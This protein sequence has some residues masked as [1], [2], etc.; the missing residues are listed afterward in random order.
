MH[1]GP[2][3]FKYPAAL[4]L[5]SDTEKDFQVIAVRQRRMHAVGAFDDV[6]HF[7][8]DIH[9]LIQNAF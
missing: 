8:Y 4:L 7:R 6:Q 5:C 3:S 1:K 2:V 9:D